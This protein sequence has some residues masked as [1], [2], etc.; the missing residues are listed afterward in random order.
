VV[1][2]Q[3]PMELKRAASLHVRVT[4]RVPDVIPFLDQAAVVVAPLRSGGGM[5]VKILDAL[6]AGKAIVASPLAVEGLDVRD[7]QEV[8]LAES[9]Q[10][11]CNAIVRLLGDAE[12]RWS[13]A[14]H[15]RDWACGHLSWDKSVRAYEALYEGLLTRSASS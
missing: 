15:A 4:G 14:T 7:G 6:A 11:F 13:L 1:G 10:G 12:M 8:L 9:D 2:D 5:R 3:P